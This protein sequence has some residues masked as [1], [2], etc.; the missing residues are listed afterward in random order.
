ML[1]SIAGRCKQS[2]LRQER[3]GGKRVFPLIACW[4]NCLM[5]QNPFYNPLYLKGRKIASHEDETQGSEQADHGVSAA[6]LAPG[7]RPARG[8]QRVLLLCRTPRRSPSTAGSPDPFVSSSSQGG[9]TGDRSV[10]MCLLVFWDELCS[11]ALC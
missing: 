4:N 10:P 7:L 9:R 8:G 1:H 11:A 3:R 2:R 5:L 6:H